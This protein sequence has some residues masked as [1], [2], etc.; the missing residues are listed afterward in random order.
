MWAHGDISVVIVF[1]DTCEHCDFS[2]FSGT[3]M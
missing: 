3:V 2:F 1:E